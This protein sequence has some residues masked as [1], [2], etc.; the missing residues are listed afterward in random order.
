VLRNVK[1]LLG[2]PVAALDKDEAGRVDNFFFDDQAWGIRYLVVD[3]GVWL[4]GR[5]VLIAPAALSK[6]DWSNG[7]SFPINLTGEEIKNSP[8]IDTDKPVSRQ[9]EVSLVAYY[10]WPAYWSTTAPMALGGVGLSPGAYLGPVNMVTGSQS[11]TH[12]QRLAEET[13]TRE[14]EGDPHLQSANKVIG[15]YIGANDGDIGHVEDFVVDDEG[16]YIRYLVIDT[17][18]WLPGKKVLIDPRWIE[19]V[20]WAESKVSIALPQGAIKN[21][22]EYDPN[23]PLDR[24]Y[25]TQL[26][27]YYDR[28]TYWKND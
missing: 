25:E 17:R 28:P 4:P 16:W 27:D 20:S 8:D 15:Y 18:N 23:T 14:H 21:S 5:K 3:T 24:A 19:G 1:G 12:E 13:Q 11:Q 10:Q 26:Y 6:L 22:P 2:C 9:Q 7:T